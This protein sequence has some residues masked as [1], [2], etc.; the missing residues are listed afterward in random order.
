MEGKGGNKGWK[1]TINKQFIYTRTS[2]LLSFSTGL[3]LY[4]LYS[5]IFVLISFLQCKVH[6]YIYERKRR[7]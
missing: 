1:S 7:R 3:V 6:S 2:R 5:F 4:K